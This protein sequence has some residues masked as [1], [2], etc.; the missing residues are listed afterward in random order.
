MSYFSLKSKFH[1][2]SQ[3]ASGGFLPASC[4]FSFE[5][6]SSLTEQSTFLSFLQSI[7][8]LIIQAIFSFSFSQNPLSFQSDFLFLLL[9][10]ALE[11]V[12]F[13]FRSHSWSGPTYS[14]TEV[15]ETE[16]S[17]APKLT[18]CHFKRSIAKPQ[19]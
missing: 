9:N 19:H 16:F 12:S 3:P 15:V 1:F 4:L 13:S 10:S 7:L 5:P 14:R 6:G 2:L 17:V 11:T 8:S 18:S